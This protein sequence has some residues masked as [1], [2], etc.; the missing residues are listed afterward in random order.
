MQSV[1]QTQQKKDAMK[2]TCKLS[3]EKFETQL[4][5]FQVDGNQYSGYKKNESLALVRHIINVQM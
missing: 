5:A 1:N 4:N 2:K 3:M